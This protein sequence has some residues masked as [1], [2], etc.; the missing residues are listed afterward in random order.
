[1]TP[2]RFLIIYEEIPEDTRF[3]EVP[4]DALG[5]GDIETLRSLHGQY[6]NLDDNPLFAWFEGKFWTEEG[7]KAEWA[8]K[9]EISEAK[10]IRLLFD[11]VEIIHTGIML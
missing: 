6:L 4:T 10:K 1:M 7:E 3:F 2:R 11:E 5:A 8:K 9:Y